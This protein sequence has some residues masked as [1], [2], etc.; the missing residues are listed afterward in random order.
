VLA[1]LF[2]STQGTTPADVD[3]EDYRVH[4]QSKKIA[5]LEAELA[6]LAAAKG[7]GTAAGLLKTYNEA[8]TAWLEAS[9]YWYFGGSVHTD[10]R[11]EKL[12]AATTSTAPISTGS[13][14]NYAYWEATVTT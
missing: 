8:N 6:A 4:G 12:F 3:C 10:T 11:T 7:D 14:T 13:G 1:A 9:R 5:D 2:S